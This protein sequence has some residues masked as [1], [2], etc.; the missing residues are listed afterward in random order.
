[1]N[2]I[3]S[4]LC[5]CVVHSTFRRLRPEDESLEYYQGKQSQ[6]FD[7]PRLFFFP[8]FCS[9][10]ML[11]NKSIKVCTV[12]HFLGLCSGCVRLFPPALQLSSVFLYCSPVTAVITYDPCQITAVFICPLYLLLLAICFQTCFVLSISLKWLDFFSLFPWVASLHYPFLSL[13]LNPLHTFFFS[14][15]IPCFPSNVKKKSLQ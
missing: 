1:M 4:I 5:C 9:C 13:Q 15:R 6:T 14:L 12:P 11:H 7:S 8:I 3:L 10:A 2:C